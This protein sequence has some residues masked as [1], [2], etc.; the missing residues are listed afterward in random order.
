MQNVDAESARIS[1]PG[2][3]SEEIDLVHMN[4]LGPDELFIDVRPRPVGDLEVVKAERL[5]LLLRLEWSDGI[6][7]WKASIE[8][9]QPWSDTARAAELTVSKLEAVS[10]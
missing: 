2:G 1:I 7:E 4:E 10:G 3:G 6:S 9:G 5:V 8:R